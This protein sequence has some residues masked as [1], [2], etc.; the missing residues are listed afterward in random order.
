[1][2]S[3]VIALQLM[4]ASP[5]ADPLQQLD[6]HFGHQTAGFKVNDVI[7]PAF[8]AQSQHERVVPDSK[9]KLH[10]IA[11]VPGVRRGENGFPGSNLKGLKQVPDLA[12]FAHQLITVRK[13]SAVR[14]HFT[15]PTNSKMHAIHEAKIIAFFRCKRLGARQYYVMSSMPPAPPPSPMDDYGPLTPFL[16]SADVSE[17]MVNGPNK[18][19]VEQAGKITQVERRFPTEGELLRVVRQLLALAGKTMS[20]QTPLIDCRLSD[21]SRM[22]VTTPP[23]TAQTC[24]TIRRPTHRTHELGELV[25]RGTL[26]APLAELLRIAV[27]MRLNILISGGTSCGKTT[28]L[29]ALASS[30]PKSNRIVTI[31]DTFEISLPHPN[32]VALETVSHGRGEGKIVI[33]MRSLVSHA[34]HL[35]PDRIIMGE[36]RSGEALDLLQAMNS[37]HDGSLATIHASTPLDVIS[38]LETLVLMSGYE[39]PLVAIRQQISRAIHLIVQMRR[40]SDGNR[41]IIAVSEITGIEDG[42][43]TMQDIFVYGRNQQGQVGFFPTGRPPIFL[44]HAAAYGIQVPGNLLNTAPPQAA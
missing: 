13:E 17:V 32:W 18:I 5:G 39:I 12:L 21:G 34:L 20:P 25:T 31:E 2:P 33:D 42:R 23:V 19:F 43:V 7:E 26:S 3:T 35:R 11:V 36:V 40:A 44:Q 41:H 37:G 30:I 38:R 8:L 22:T 16:A 14:L 6:G 27:Q 28:L 9:R 15:P 10:L 4:V 1:M 24:F 29:N